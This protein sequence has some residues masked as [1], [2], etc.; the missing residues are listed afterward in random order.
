MAKSAE[1]KGRE[2]FYMYNKLLSLK[3]FKHFLIGNAVGLAK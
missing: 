2:N 3:L 1:Q